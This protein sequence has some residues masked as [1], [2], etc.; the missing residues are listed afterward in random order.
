MTNMSVE[1]EATKQIDDKCSL[2]EKCGF[3]VGNT[4]GRGAYAVVKEGMSKK[5]NRKVAIK[6]ISKYIAPREYLQRFLLRELEVVSTLRHDNLIKYY[7]GI[8]TSH[9]V[10][11][12]MEYA[13]NG[14]LLDAI[15]KERYIDEIRS[16]QWFIQLISAVMYIHE[17][18][19]VHRDIKCENILLDNEL[20]I[21]L[22][23]FGFARGNMHP[24]NGRYPLSTTYCG[25][26][27]YAAPEVL[28]GVPYHPQMAD[29]WS[30]GVVLY[31]MVFGRL[32]FDDTN[33]ASLLKQVSDKV[34]FPRLPVT[35]EP[36]KLLIR[37][38]LSPA[39]LRA[40]IP[41]IL[42]DTWVLY[43]FEDES[44]SPTTPEEIEEKKDVAPTGGT[45]KDTDQSTE[46]E[47]NTGKTTINE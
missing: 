38:I 39:K 36:V 43:S 14:T 12:I 41:E 27:S 44:M 1:T 26:Y 6:I 19:V 37:R 10:Y 18:G 42:N 21:K 3:T 31:A 28:R 45:S 15:R 7:Q 33:F 24:E 47:D 29:I 30:T 32:P 46:E 2:I 4:I 25:S 5:Y 20:Q 22:S 8:E 35:S 9:R 34:V 16:K 23:D 13:S 11:V 17:R 40:T